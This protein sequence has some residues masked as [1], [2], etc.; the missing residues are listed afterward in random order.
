MYVKYSTN[1]KQNAH[2]LCL[3]SRFISQSFCR[4]RNKYHC[5]SVKKMKCLFKILFFDC[6]HEIKYK[7]RKM[8]KHVWGRDQSG[9]GC[10]FLPPPPSHL[11][12][13]FTLPTLPPPSYPFR[14]PPYLLPASSLSFA[15]SSL[16]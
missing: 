3:T 12:Y 16:L 1:L 8:K 15:P 2:T 13:L 9:T 7:S 10:H 11:P 4:L 5:D 14:P 6:K